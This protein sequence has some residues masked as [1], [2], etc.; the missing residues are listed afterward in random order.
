MMR[1]LRKNLAVCVVAKVLQIIYWISISLI[2]AEVL[3][4]IKFYLLIG[5]L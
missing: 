1:Y 2:I 5:V 4:G 3:I